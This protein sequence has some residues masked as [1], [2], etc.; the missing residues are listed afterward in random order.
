M[1]KWLALAK[2]QTTAFGGKNENY[3]NLFW[4]CALWQ[5]GDSTPQ[6]DPLEPK[7]GPTFS[8]GF[9]LSTFYF[10]YKLSFFCAQSGNELVNRINWF[11]CILYNLIM[12][13]KSTGE[14]TR[15]GEIGEHFLFLA[16]VFF[17]FG[18]ANCQRKQRKFQKIFIEL[19]IIIQID[20]Y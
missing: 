6:R 14:G 19:E 4:T 5:M 2:R 7:V 12:S 10:F 1:N 13:C 11:I 16:C 9:F 18:W 8:K 3:Q 15:E 17:I 20:L